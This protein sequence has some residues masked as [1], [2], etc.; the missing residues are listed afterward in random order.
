MLVSCGL[1]GTL[2]GCFMGGYLADL[3]AVIS[4]DHG[5]IYIG[6]LGGVLM[7]GFWLG[8]MWVPR[9][10][11]Y[12]VW[13]GA[14]FFMFGFVKNWEYVGAIRPILV[15]VAPSHRRGI[16]IAYAA[17]FDGMVSATL[18]GPLVGLLAEKVYG[19]ERTTLEVAEMPDD[20]RTGNLE[21]LTQAIA[22]VTV[23]CIVGNLLA[24]SILHRTYAR[25]RALAKLHDE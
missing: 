12:G 17:C 21:A 14:M 15:E 19:Y 22:S 3:F 7:L 5:R 4:P 13:L 8:L 9:E 1:F 18:G 10:T 23:V 25:D 20:Q 11:D 6:Q 24:F 16:V 2:I